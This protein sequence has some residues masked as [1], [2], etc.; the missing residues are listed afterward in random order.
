MTIKDWKDLLEKYPDE[1]LVE[2]I[3]F[4]GVDEK[5]SWAPPEVIDIHDVSISE[6]LSP[7]E[8]NKYKFLKILIG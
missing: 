7:D 5:D 4:R 6:C 8:K 1:M 2:L 3:T